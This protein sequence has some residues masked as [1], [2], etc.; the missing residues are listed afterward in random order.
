LGTVDL[1]LEV[2]GLDGERGDRLR[3]GGTT[4]DAGEGGDQNRERHHEMDSAH[5]DANP[6]DPK[7]VAP[8]IELRGGAKRR[9]SRRATEAFRGVRKCTPQEAPKERNAEIR[10]FPPPT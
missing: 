9:R 2:R 8:K 1:D 7:R 10:R 5:G 6:P 4:A 3:T